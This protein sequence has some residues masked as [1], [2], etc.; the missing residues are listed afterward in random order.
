[1]SLRAPPREFFAWLEQNRVEHFVLRGGHRVLDARVKDLDLLIDDRAI[2]AL[3]AAF[4]GRRSGLKFDCYGIRGLHGSDYRG[5][6][7]LPE[8]LGRQV[9]AQRRLVAGIWMPQPLDELNALL[10][11][12]AYHKSL[13]SGVHVSDPARSV[14]NPNTERLAALQSECGVTVPCTLEGFHRHL[15]SCD[16]SVSEARLVAY[17]EYDFRHGRKSFFHARLQDR[18]PGELNLFVIREVAVRHGKS[19]AFI[20]RLR[21]RFR[22]VS[23]KAIDWWTRLARARHMRGGKWRRGGRPRVAVVVFDLAPVP[24]TAEEREVHPFVFNRNQFVK[25]EWRDWFRRETGARAKDN[26]IHSTDN[27]A[28]ALGHL[29]LFFSAEE[30]EGIRQSLPALRAEASR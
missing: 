18:H 11:H 12:M 23:V 21:E 30:R 10:Y 9:L 8:R 7:H 2:T 16:L 6:P 20:E 5:F 26:P 14:E 27:E 1:M 24:T 13:Q 19:E 29:P 4:Q 3:R 22:I 15:E 17:I 28:E 25:V